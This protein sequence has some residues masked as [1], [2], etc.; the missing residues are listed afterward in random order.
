MASGGPFDNTLPG[1]TSP[2]GPYQVTLYGA[3]PYPDQ[4]WA[5]EPIT[6]WTPPVFVPSIDLDAVRKMVEAM[7][8]SKPG[9][10]D[11]PPS[12]ATRELDAIRALV[13]A[14]ES[15]FALVKSLGE[16]LSAEEKARVLRYMEDRYGKGVTGE[17]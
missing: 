13:T 5:P 17:R 7:M 1:L 11:P 8:K 3:S 16:Q 6:P 15:Y 9:K 4:P 14:L 2:R 10:V 12:E